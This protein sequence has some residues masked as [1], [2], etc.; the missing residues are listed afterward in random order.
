MS[1]KLQRVL[2]ILKNIKAKIWLTSKKRNTALHLPIL[3]GAEL[4]ISSY[5]PT[6][7]WKI[8]WVYMQPV[9]LKQLGFFFQ[10]I[11]IKR[12]S[13]ND[14]ES[15]WILQDILCLS[16]QSEAVK[17][18]GLKM[19]GYMDDRWCV[20]LPPKKS[21]NPCS[22]LPRAYITLGYYKIL[23]EGTIVV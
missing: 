7:R 20:N 2:I 17:L 9:Q 6:R 16:S 19:T 1:R 4:N 18:L 3:I 22:Q 5:L 13:C 8:A 21:C 11:T 14:F 23:I 10:T 15:Q 12:K